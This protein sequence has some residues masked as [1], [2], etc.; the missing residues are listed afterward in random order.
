MKTYDVIAEIYDE[1]MQHV[2]YRKWAEY[3]LD[4]LKKHKHEPGKVLE[5]AC[6]TGSITKELQ[7]NKIEVTGLDLSL[8]MVQAAVQKLKKDHDMSYE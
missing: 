8:P 1:I 7:R 6:G 2:D 5:L 3:I 4:I